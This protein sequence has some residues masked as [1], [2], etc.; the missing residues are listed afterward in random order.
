MGTMPIAIAKTIK[1]RLVTMA[2]QEDS[3]FES[4][5]GVINYDYGKKNIK[6]RLGLIN[7]KVHYLIVVTF[8]ATGMGRY[9]K[10]IRRVFNYKTTSCIMS[11]EKRNSIVN[12]RK[13]IDKIPDTKIILSSGSIIPQILTRTNTVVQIDNFS[14]PRPQYHI[15][16]LTKNRAGDPSPMT[17]E[18]LDEIYKRCLPVSSK[19]LYEDKYAIVMQGPFTQDCIKIGS[20]FDLKNGYRSRYLKEFKVKK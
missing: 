5:N 14:V 8:I 11:K 1:R 19:V 2:D 20:Y 15:M 6:F 3:D 17:Q 4:I 10:A 9:N 13:V 7:S 16:A 12:V 18:K